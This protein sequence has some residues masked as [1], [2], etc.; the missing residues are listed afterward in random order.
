M[1]D[2]EDCDTAADEERR[3]DDDDDDEPLADERAAGAQSD[4][5]SGDATTHGTGSSDVEIT[6]MGLR[7]GGWVG[8]S[9]DAIFVDRGDERVKIHDDAV[10]RIGLRML[11]WDTAVL[12]LLL[13]GVGAYVV[14]T[15]N[16]LVGLGFAAVG[17]YSLYRTYDDRQA[18]VI[19]VEDRRK[20]VAVHPEHPAE[21]HERLAAE[22]GLEEP[23]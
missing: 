15:R 19:H 17:A 2:D 14:S 20:P 7:N 22:A 23:T 5:R 6:R 12:S 9:A 13:V 16:P 3:D 21:C 10:S 4:P 18:V 8:Y 1:T 11:A